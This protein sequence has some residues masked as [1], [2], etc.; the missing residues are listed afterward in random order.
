MRGR[1]FAGA[2]YR[3]RLFDGALLNG[4]DEIVAAQTDYR[5]GR[6]KRED[7]DAIRRLVYEKYEAIEQSRA[8]DEREAERVARSAFTEDAVPVEAISGQAEAQ[9]ISA[10]VHPSVAVDDVALRRVKA[11]NEEMLLLLALSEMDD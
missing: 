2:L 9:P 4:L 11:R 8:R 7:E 5:G 3:G 10:L 1:L 6:K